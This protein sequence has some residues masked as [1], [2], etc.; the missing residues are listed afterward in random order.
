MNTHKICFYGERTI[1]QA[2]LLSGILLK[3]KGAPNKLHLKLKVFIN[4]AFCCI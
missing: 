1:Y 3:G 2:T 4:Q